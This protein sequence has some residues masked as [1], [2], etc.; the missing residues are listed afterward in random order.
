MSLDVS[1]FEEKSDDSRQR[2]IFQLLVALQ[3]QGLDVRQSRE[4]VSL[5]ALIAV[6]EVREIE[7]LGLAQHWPPLE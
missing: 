6:E 4:H 2:A 3:D 1:T 7:K 5:Q